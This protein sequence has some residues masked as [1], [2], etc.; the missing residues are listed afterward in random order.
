MSE[1]MERFRDATERQASKAGWIRGS[2]S[3]R[4]AF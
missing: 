3:E 1:S 4:M 2:V